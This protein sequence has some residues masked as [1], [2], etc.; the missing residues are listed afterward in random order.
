MKSESGK[1]K[2][3]EFIKEKDMEVVKQ[4]QYNLLLN[5]SIE[6]HTYNCGLTAL[7]KQYNE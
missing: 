6:L 4:P 5:S 3:M 7:K 2:P 1:K